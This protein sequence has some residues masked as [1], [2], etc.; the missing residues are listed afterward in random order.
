VD[1]RPRT[2]SEAVSSLRATSRRRRAKKTVMVG[3]AI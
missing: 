2:G 3:E 1:H